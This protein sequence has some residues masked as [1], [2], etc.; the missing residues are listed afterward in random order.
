MLFSTNSII[1]SLFV[2]V[3]EINIRNINNLCKTLSCITQ[4]MNEGIYVSYN[5]KYMLIKINY[6]F[7]FGNIIGF[8]VVKNISIRLCKL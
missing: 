4:I 5:D 8:I 3:S 7:F 2:N 6:F 1:D